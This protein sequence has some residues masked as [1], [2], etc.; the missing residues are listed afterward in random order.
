MKTIITGSRRIIES[1][2][3]NR[4]VIKSEFEVIEVVSRIIRG[5][6]R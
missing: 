5:W 1:K 2:K 4:A 3:V 6:T